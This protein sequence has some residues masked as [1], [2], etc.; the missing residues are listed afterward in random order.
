MSIPISGNFLVVPDACVLWPASLRDTLLRLAETPAQYIPKWTEEIWQEVVR[1]LQARRG[2]TA[3]QTEYL[4]KQIRINFPE[5]FVTGYEQFAAFMA[6]DPKDR[7]VVAA[8]VRCNAQLIV[9]SN[10]KDFSPEALQPWGIAAQHPDDFLISQYDLNPDVVISKL[11][12]QAA[13]INRPLVGLLGT[14]RKGVPNFAYSIAQRL[15]LE[16]E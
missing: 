11:H 14:L 2:V 1:N 3:A 12:E 15:G 13:T 10:L 9:T 7:H 16:L 8:A 5:S 4:L 6:N